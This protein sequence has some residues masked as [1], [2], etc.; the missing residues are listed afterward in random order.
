MDLH[1]LCLSYSHAEIARVLGISPRCLQD[2]KRGYTA[3]TV[4]D[5]FVLERTFPQFNTISTI[6]RI[7]AVRE[8]KGKSRQIRNALRAA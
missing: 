1:E 4:D 8:A 6:R 3:L 5:L 7:G 2:M